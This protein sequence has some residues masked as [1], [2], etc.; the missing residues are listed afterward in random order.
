M[1][2]TPEGAKRAAQTAKDRYGATWHA[3]N[4]RKGGELG[5]GTI[6]SRRRRASRRE[7]DK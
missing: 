4:G 1:G 7:G 2:N 3:E 5:K 6:K